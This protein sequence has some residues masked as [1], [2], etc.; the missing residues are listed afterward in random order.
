MITTKKFKLTANEYF[1]ILLTVYLKKKWWLMLFLI[2]M[3]L[4]NIVGNYKSGE[5][6]IW[7]GIIYPVAV[8]FQLWRYAN[9]KDNREISVERY[10]EISN[11]EIIGYRADGSESKVMI[12]SFIKAVS[13]KNYYLLYVSKGQ[14]VCISANAFNSDN[15]RTRFI[16]EII[17]R[18]QN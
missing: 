7:F 1:K 6:F 3:A 8:A 2:F 5:F 16:R 9:S 14:F 10:Y 17:G 12:N 4:I 11:S 13:L 18:I 15:E